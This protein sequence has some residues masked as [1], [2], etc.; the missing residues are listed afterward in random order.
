V[1]RWLLPLLTLGFIWVIFSRFA[2]IERLVQTLAEGRWRW[3]LAAFL[4]QALYFIVYAASFRTSFAAVGIPSRM[5][6]L[7]PLTFAAIFANTTA[8]TGGA[9]GGAVLID[10]AARRGY[11]HARAA[12]GFLLQ[13]ATD[14]GAFCLMLIVGLFVLAQ[15]A[16]LHWYELAAALILLLY[17]ASISGALLLGLWLPLWLHKLLAWLQRQVNRL[18]AWVRKPALLN[19]DWSQRN[20]EELIEASKAIAAHPRML[21]LT[22]LVTVVLHSLAIATLYVL[23]YAFNQPVEFEVV[24]AGYSMIILFSIISPTPNGVGLVEGL[25][26]IVFTSLNIPADIATIVIL[27]FRGITFW[28]P[29]LIGFVLMQRLPIFTPTERQMAR[30]GQVNLA[31]LAT[32]AMGVLNVLSA[33]TPGLHDRVA[34]IAAVSPL[35]VQN[36]GRLTAV[37]AGFALLLLARGLWRHK[38]VA[39]LLTEIVLL[40]S[41]AAHLIKGLDY[42]EATLAALLAGYL[43]FQRER[44]HA[45]SDPPS[46]YQGLMTLVTAVLFTLAYGIVGFYL[47]DRHFHVHFSLSAAAAQTLI[48]FTAFYDPGLQPISGFGRYFANSIYVVGAATL[49]YAL[50][51]LLR[52]VLRR[53]PADEA[54]RR[55]AQAI[56]K[57]H[58]STSLARFVLF[59]DKS[60]WFSSGGS[61]VAYAV[62]RHVA[63]ALGD[64]IGPESDAKTA[65]AEFYAFC[66]HNDW[67]SAFYQVQPDYVE[68]YREMGYDVLCIG[69]EG[70][71]DL[72][73]F[74]LSGGKYKHLRTIA[75][76][77]DKNGYRAE[78]LEP[79]LDDPQLV[80]LN[81]VSDEWLSLAHGKERRFS[82]GWFDEEYVRSTPV[83]VIYAPDGSICAFANLV[84]EYNR[85]ELAVDLMRH[86]RVVENGVMDYLFIS[87]FLW[88]KAQG[89]SSFNLGL[90]ALSGV[91]EN[92]DDPTMERA[93]HYIYKHVNQFYNFRGLHEFK[94]KFHPTWSPRYLVFPGYARLPAVGFTLE[95]AGSGPDFL[96]DYAVTLVPRLREL[97]R[98]RRT[99]GEATTPPPHP[100]PLASQPDSESSSR[101]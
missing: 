100:K 52:P 94:E 76:Y 85:N 11:S 69:H 39:W 28:L 43:W 41:V 6:D 15:R 13:M 10:D 18:G 79:L 53:R 24:I 64:P 2:E 1:R 21:G 55:R 67:A 56:V 19:E 48:M 4:L 70:L 29:L 71:V 5:R 30:S 31:A 36:G 58:G 68:D 20:A 72:T 34:L 17:V 81:E 22:L 89:Y 40:L 87:L 9:A 63:V 91:G 37:L 38:Q 27:A 65:V 33:A 8:P 80:A 84:T 35:E 3:I 98:A 99:Q 83:M 74:T 88:A 45:L 23:F 57:E 7:I 90:S 32:T 44:F 51:M 47:L 92:P 49:G 54:H 50:W 101:S 96:L 60:Y 62:R 77:F 93:L 12:A 14:Y 16:D 25:M 26:P 75:H 66:A 86:R 78:M 42:E 73:T 46:L 59:P 95:S 97:W 61:V 82:M